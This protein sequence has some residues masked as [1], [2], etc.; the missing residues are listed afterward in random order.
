LL[1]TVKSIK[2]L[3]H[4]SSA[5]FYSQILIVY[6][7]GVRQILW[8]LISIKLDSSL[9]PGRRTFWI[10]S[11]DLEIPLCCE[12]I[13]LRIWECI[14][15]ATSFSSSCQFFFT[16]TE[17]TFLFP[18]SSVY[19]SYILLWSV[20]NW[21]MRLSLGSLLWLLIQINLRAYKEN[22]QP[23]TTIDFSNIW[24][25]MMIIYQK[26][27]GHNRRRYFDAFFLINIFSGTKCCPSVLEIVGLR[28]PTRNIPNFNT[29][30]CSSSYFSSATWASTA[31]AVC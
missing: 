13:V 26:D 8:S 3:V 14:L 10:I 29:F 25:I 4:L 30:T 21:N 2:Q 20:L 11:T 15:I 19:W 28:I 12:Q 27:Y 6:I 17:I 22:L 9:L 1:R 31:N 23:F 16:C 18:P 7:N 24:I 5:F